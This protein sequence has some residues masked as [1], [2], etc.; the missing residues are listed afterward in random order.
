[1]RRLN[2]KDWMKTQPKPYESNTIVHSLRFCASSAETFHR[3]RRQKQKPFLATHST[4]LNPLPQLRTDPFSNF[5]NN[6]RYLSEETAVIKIAWRR[7]YKNFISFLAVSL[8][9]CSYFTFE[10]AKG[11][12]WTWRDATAVNQETFALIISSTITLLCQ[13][14]WFCIEDI[15]LNCHME[16][17]EG[18]LPS[19][20]YKYTF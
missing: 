10:L 1:M 19:R 14:L 13:L 8:E 3:R 9:Q 7:S 20:P 5:A 18:K 4:F 17:P 12:V 6:S 2:D 16:S 11:K 15:I